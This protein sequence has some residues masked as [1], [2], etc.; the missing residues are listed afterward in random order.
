[1]SVF[2]DFGPLDERIQVIYQGTDRFVVLS[3]VDFVDE[4]WTVCVALADKGRWWRTTWG[5]KEVERIM[6]NNSFESIRHILIIVFGLGIICD[7]IY[8]ERS[9]RQPCTRTGERN[10]TYTWMA[11]S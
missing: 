9:S 6:V 1:M 10:I 7:F 11:L 3:N 2:D 5:A 8:T 4:S